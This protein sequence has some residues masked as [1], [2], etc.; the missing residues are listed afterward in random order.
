MR[1]LAHD[2]A[3]PSSLGAVPALSSSHA[4][5]PAL[6][7]SHAPVPALPGSH[8]PFPFPASSLT[9]NAP[10][11]GHAKEESGQLFKSVHENGKKRYDVDTKSSFDVFENIVVEICAEVSSN[12]LSE[13]IVEAIEKVAADLLTDIVAEKCMEMCTES[14][15]YAKNSHLESVWVFPWL[16]MKR[17][18]DGSCYWKSGNVFEKKTSYPLLPALA[19]ATQAE[20]QAMEHSSGENVVTNEKTGQCFKVESRYW[21][22]MKE[23][24]SEQPPEMLSKNLKSQLFL[25][26]ETPRTKELMKTNSCVVAPY[27]LWAK[28]ILKCLRVGFDDLRGNQKPTFEVLEISDKD[29]RRMPLRPEVV[30][31]EAFVDKWGRDVFARASR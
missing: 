16:P 10:T 15:T 18:S 21:N 8:A 9:T 26:V 20:N 5:L 22:L 11:T 31:N 1:K 4:P 27:G 12:V 3:L 6:P 7:S 25:W 2:R 29:G 24:I 23:E 13:V 17:N 19:S 14:I 30:L 28:D